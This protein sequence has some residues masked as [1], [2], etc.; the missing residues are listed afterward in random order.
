MNIYIAMIV[1]RHTN[2]YASAFKELD[3]AIAWIK[4]ELTEREWEYEDDE[5]MTE[6]E[7]RDVRWFYHKRYSCEGDYAF[8]EISELK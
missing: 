6:D 2:P 1:D 8:V 4:S 3:D 7:L 5:P